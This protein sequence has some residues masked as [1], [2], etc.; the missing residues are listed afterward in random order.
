MDML[1]EQFKTIFDRPGKVK[2]LREYILQLAV[3]GKLVEQD[4]N[5]EP[6]SVL[7]KKIKEEK[8][9]LVKEKK[10]KKQK[11]LPEIGE[12]EV[13][14]ELSRGWEWVRLID[15][16]YNLGQ[17]KP[18]QKFT[19]IDVGSINK[20]LGILGDDENI[21]T[22]E[23]A[24]SRARKLVG[25]GTIIYS[26]V[27]P[28][29]LNIAIIDKSFKYEPIVSTAFA[30][31]HPYRGVYNR[32]IYH[33]LRSIIFM[34]Y[35]ESQMV[36]M[37]YPAIND[38]KLF[39]GVVPLPPPKE[40]KRIVEKVDFLMGFCDK[41]EAH[42]EKKVK[43]GALSSKSIFN[44]IGNCKSSEELEEVL[45]F[46]IMNFKELTL[47]DDAVKELKNGILQ[48]A[49]QG[50]LVP[51][52]EN[53][54]PANV[55]LE[56]IKE[57]KD[58]LVKEK[59]IKKGTVLPEI[60]EDEVPYELPVG[61]EWVRLNNITICRDGERVPVSKVQ[62]EKRGKV[63]DYYG[64]S[65]VIDKIDGYIFNKPLL[66]IGEDGA[67]LINR[68]KAI[69][70]IAEGKYWVNN[71]A[72]ILDSID[73]NILKYLSIYV[74]SIDLKPFVTGTAQPKM[75]QAKMNSIPVAVPPLNEQKR[76]V[77]KVDSLMSL[78]DELQKSIDQSKKNSE[79]LMES[80]LQE[81]FRSN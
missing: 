54:E 34:N 45:R 13:P 68:S 2:K 35:V 48:L 39:K 74:N 49:V 66:L 14:Y 59:K 65:G 7:L 12:D 29:L 19:Y 31:I 26:T 37:A 78:C 36:G 67:N 57:E 22:A 20:E 42:L 69:A 25:D 18:N 75:N 17:K 41:L 60:S 10:I 46:I 16:G 33:Y 38:Q 79:L 43:Y 63:Y 4:E 64:A 40:Q 81:A 55:L 62:R 56:K 44:S 80:I 8:E 73:L 76:I 61:W 6:A 27:R 71:H 50:K 15:V 32:Y 52:D 1:L 9:K 21:L 72:H 11:A 3:R 51:Q 58:R 53:D 5:D 28:Y 77:D 23:E 70:F 24:P 47:G 30:I